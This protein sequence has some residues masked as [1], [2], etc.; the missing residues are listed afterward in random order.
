MCFAPDSVN[1]K[2]G[3]GYPY[4]CGHVSGC[5]AIQFFR[6]G[7]SGH[8]T[9]IDNQSKNMGMTAKT[10]RFVFD[11]PQTEGVFLSVPSLS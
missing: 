2:R 9:M 11:V 10:T 3:A 5:R 6:M 8:K 1:I 4:A 7:P